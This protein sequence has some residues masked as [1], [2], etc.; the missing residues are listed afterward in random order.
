[1]D[2]KDIK[3]LKLL[4]I[5]ILTVLIIFACLYGGKNYEHTSHQEKLDQQSNELKEAWEDVKDADASEFNED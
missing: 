2:K 1:M 5:G 3:T 4:M